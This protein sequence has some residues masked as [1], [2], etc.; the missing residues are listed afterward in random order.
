MPPPPKKKPAALELPYQA[1]LSSRNRFNGHL[2]EKTI[3]KGAGKAQKR[4][5]LLHM[6]YGTRFPS[7]ASRASRHKPAP[8][9]PAALAPRRCRQTQPR[10]DHKTRAG[11][12]H[13]EKAPLAP[14]KKIAS[15]Y[16]N[17]EGLLAMSALRPQFKWS[18]PPSALINSSSR[19]V[20]KAE[21]WNVEHSRLAAR[22]RCRGR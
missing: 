14:R 6:G 17:A 21:A 20:C 9:R 5:V 11:M 8:P 15:G 13:N 16:L 22:P 7:S 4:H 10:R 12:K 18:S 19:H 3:E 1:K 2:S